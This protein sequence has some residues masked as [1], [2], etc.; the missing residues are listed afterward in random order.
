MLENKLNHLSVI[1]DGNR[2]WAKLNNLDFFEGHKKGSDNIELLLNLAMKNEIKYLSIYAFS[3]ENWLRSSQEISYLKDLIIYYLN[4]QE[5]YFINN[6]IKV[7]VIGD[8]SAFGAKISSKIESL[9][10]K[11]QSF[12]KLT[13]IIALNYGARAEIIRA[14]ES[15][16]LDCKNQKLPLSALDENLF[17]KYL[18]TKD[19]PDPDLL[20]RTGGEKRLSNFLLWQLS[21]AELFFEDTMWP[22]FNEDC[23]NNAMNA[24]YLRERRVGK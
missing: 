9:I 10:N 11:T 8:Y 24:F 15:L 13:F 6:Q 1:M 16:L 18:Y 22:D 12:N 5:D 14:V 17:S 23:F 3:S 2:R 20:I 7:L 19:I 21:Y 4:K